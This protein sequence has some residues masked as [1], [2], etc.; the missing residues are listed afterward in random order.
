[1][2]L[3]IVSF[4]FL[5]IA[6]SYSSENDTGTGC[7]HYYSQPLNK[8]VYTTTDIEPEFAGG[9]AAYQRFL[10]RHLRYPQEMIDIE[11]FENVSSMSKMKFIVDTDGRII[12]PVVHDQSDTTLLNP[13][14]K[15]VLRIIRLMPKWQP[16]VCGGK[17]VAAEV[18]KPMFICIRLESEE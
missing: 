12:N 10:N 15:E 6:G 17:I 8:N 1:M 2:K 11:E 9:P 3:S 5:F 13:F 16:G 7:R 4:V 14:E 18:N